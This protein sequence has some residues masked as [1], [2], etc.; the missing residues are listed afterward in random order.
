MFIHHIDA[1]EEQVSETMIFSPIFYTGDHPR[2]N[3]HIVKALARSRLYVTSV[4]CPHTGSALQTLATLNGVML[5]ALQIWTET[6][7]LEI[8]SYH[9]SCL[10]C[11]R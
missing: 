1:D 7:P 6:G 11:K 2:E 5:L 3:Q 4:L 10:N 8:S 9:A